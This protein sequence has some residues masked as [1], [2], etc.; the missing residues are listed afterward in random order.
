MSNISRQK[1]LSLAEQPP[2]NYA[3]NSE[4]KAEDIAS[5]QNETEQSE[6]VSDTTD[7]DTDSFSDTN[8]E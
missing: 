3:E 8:E 1:R 7:K 5:A 6:N 2:I 4:I